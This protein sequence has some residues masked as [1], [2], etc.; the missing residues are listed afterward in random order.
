MGT[1]PHAAI[2]T[3]SFPFSPEVEAR[4]HFVALNGSISGQAVILV[5]F[6]AAFA[7]PEA[8]HRLEIK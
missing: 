1:P 3:L 2:R 5:R 6:I 8:F 4:E 7:H